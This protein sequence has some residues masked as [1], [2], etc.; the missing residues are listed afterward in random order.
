MSKVT[1]DFEEEVKKVLAV[2][3]K[4]T[5]NPNRWVLKN[6]LQDEIL[7]NWVKQGCRNLTAVK[8]SV[9]D[10]YLLKSNEYLLADE[11]TS[12][13]YNMQIH[14]ID[15]ENCVAI[16]NT[17]CVIKRINSRQFT[18]ICSKND[19]QVAVPT[20]I[21]DREPETETVR[22]DDVQELNNYLAEHG[23]KTRIEI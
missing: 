14:K 20:E 11:K 22:Q 5:K 16:I 8:L 9:F 18:A 19:L 3:E 4:D 1:T 23:I 15:V 2:N 21:L 12:S 17:S 13:M 10:L 6:A 7:T